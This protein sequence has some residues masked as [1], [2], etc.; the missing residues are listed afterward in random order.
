MKLIFLAGLA[1]LMAAPA[2]AFPE[3]GSDLSR[4]NETELQNY[5]QWVEAQAGAVSNNFVEA[6]IDGD[7]L[8]DLRGARAEYLRLL[9][10]GRLPRG[11]RAELPDDLPPPEGKLPLVGGIPVKLANLVASDCGSYPRAEWCE[12]LYSL[13]QRFYDLQNRIDVLY[14]AKP[15]H[16]L[17]KEYYATDAALKNAAAKL[18]VLLPDNLTQIRDELYRVRSFLDKKNSAAT[19][20]TSY[21]PSMQ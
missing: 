20:G 13:S 21:G 16:S 14:F 7:W 12:D 5:K 19:N 6:T 3:I 17:Q 4:L 9:S 2:L 18:Y 8:G 10:S 11:V 1:L 15:E